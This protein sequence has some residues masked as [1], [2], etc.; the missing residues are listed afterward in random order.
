MHRKGVFVSMN[1]LIETGW[2]IYASENQVII[3]LD[4]GLPPVIIIWTNAVL[5]SIKLLGIYFSE[6][7][8]KM[9]IFSFKKMYLKKNVA[10]KMA[11]IGSRLHCGKRLPTC[12][13][14]LQC[15]KDGLQSWG[16]YE[17]CLRPLPEVRYGRLHWRKGH[18]R[19]P[20]RTVRFLCGEGGRQCR[21][22]YVENDSTQNNTCRPYWMT[23]SDP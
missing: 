13:V 15:D 17:G 8:I 10:I 2:R 1:Q 21:G 23:S 5:L 20:R 12:A 22:T 18:P 7:L 16:R 3:A 14:S 6:N 9:E 11:A 4:N 19:S